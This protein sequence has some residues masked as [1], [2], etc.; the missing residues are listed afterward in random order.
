MRHLLVY[1]KDYKKESVFAPL[2]KMLEASFDLL[3]PLVMAA[4][5][6]NGIVLQA[7]ILLPVPREDNGF[8]MNTAIASDDDFYVGFD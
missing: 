7:D 3:V 2:F 1:L 6:D 4:I 8:P 5:I